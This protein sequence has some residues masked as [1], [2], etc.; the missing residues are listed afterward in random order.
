MHRCTLI[1]HVVAAAVAG[2][3]RAVFGPRPAFPQSLRAGNRA[4]CTD[5]WLTP[6][7]TP[8]PGRADTSVHR[9]N[10]AC[11]SR[12]LEAGGDVHLHRRS[13]AAAPRSPTG[14]RVPTAGVN[15]GEVVLVLAP[16]RASPSPRPQVPLSGHRPHGQAEDPHDA[17]PRPCIS[18]GCRRGASE[19]PASR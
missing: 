5:E 1:H 16:S 8:H 10:A 6:H 18:S 13:L 14:P 17:S 7:R 3:G 4:S 19:P 9:L 12:L 2:P 15:T 11:W